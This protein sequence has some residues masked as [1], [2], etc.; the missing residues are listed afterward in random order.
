MASTSLINSLTFTS[1]TPTL[2]YLTRGTPTTS[3]RFAI[4]HRSFT[5]RRISSP[6]PVLCKAVSVQSQT[7]LDGL[8]IA[9]DVTQVRFI[10]LLFLFLR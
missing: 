6:S 2:H 7:N 4:S 3:L 8:N 1:R 10:S 9:D 5:T